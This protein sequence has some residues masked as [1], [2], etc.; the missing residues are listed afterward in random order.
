[1]LLQAMYIV[2][3]QHGVLFYYSEN[4]ELRTTSIGK[5]WGGPKLKV[6]LKF[7]LVHHKSL[8]TLDSKIT[9]D[10]NK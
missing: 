9:S 6:I 7:V 3:I 4:T 5:T 1:M 8:L 2:V 10:I